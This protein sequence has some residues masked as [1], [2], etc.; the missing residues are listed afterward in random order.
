[1][2]PDAQPMPYARTGVVDTLDGFLMVL[3]P[4]AVRTLRFDESLGQFDGYDFDF[5]LQVRAAGRKVRTIDVRA[6][7]HHG[8]HPF[9]DSESWIE[10]HMRVAEKWQGQLPGIGQAP[11]SWEERTWRAQAARDAAH[12][13]DHANKLKFDARVRELETALEETTASLSW[14]IT[15]P[16]RALETRWAARDGHRPALPALPRANAEP[17]SG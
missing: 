10:A 15:K 13:I 17:G 5:C 7:H 8:L 11:G 1:M 14:R 9:T 6:I 16:L 2:E 3:S 12:V 4:W